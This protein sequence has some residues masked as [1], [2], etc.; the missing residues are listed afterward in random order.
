MVTILTRG[1][2][3]ETEIEEGLGEACMP[4]SELGEKNFFIAGSSV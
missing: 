1:R 3:E 4:D 2:S